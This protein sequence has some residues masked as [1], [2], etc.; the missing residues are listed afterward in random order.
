MLCS[1]CEKEHVGLVCPLCGRR[2]DELREVEEKG[3]YALGPRYVPNKGRD[4]GEQLKKA[5]YV[6]VEGP[7][8]DL[9]GDESDGD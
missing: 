9:P 5:G 2:S 1:S 4:I 6:S 8:F 3:E 7:T